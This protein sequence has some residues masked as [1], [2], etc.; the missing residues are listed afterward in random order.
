MTRL[1]DKAVIAAIGREARRALLARADGPGARR[2]LLHFGLILIVGALIAARAPY[3]PALLPVQ[4]ILVIFLFSALHETIHRTAFDSPRL[5][6][7]VA[8]VCGFLILTPPR[9]FRLFHFAHHR[10]THDAGNDPEL[11]PAKA[12]TLAGYLAYMSGLP[13]W[14]SLA[15][16]LIVN[17]MGRNDDP[18]VGAKEHAK[19]SQ[20]ARWTL[21]LYALTVGASYA[22]ASD[23]LIWTWWLPALIGQPFLRGYLLA[24]HTGCPQSGD[25]LINSRTTLTNP[26]VRFI[27]WNMPYHAEHHA[28]PATPFHRLPALHDY[29]REHLGVAQIG[30]LKF[31]ADHIKG[32]RTSA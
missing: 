13:V 1:G 14:R 18:F 25:M 16:G 4:G 5:N 26:L 31:H 7:M 21:A 12:R 28:M 11:D 15:G 6:R 27:A 2:F 29:T 17:A 24:E 23:L 22:L 30:Y 20:E 3:W 32:L 19:I 10:F 9:W 8:A